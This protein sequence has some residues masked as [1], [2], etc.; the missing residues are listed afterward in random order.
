VFGTHRS[1]RGNFNNNILCI[2]KFLSLIDYHL[3]LYSYTVCLAVRRHILPSFRNINSNIT[4]FLPATESIFV[5]MR[6]C[7]C[8]RACMRARVFD[9]HCR[10]VV[11]T[12][13]SIRKRLESK[14]FVSLYKE[15]MFTNI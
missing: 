7:E 9:F 3:A 15:I 4:I 11:C 14:T 10:M 12:Y 8:M 2:L 6:M 1:I 13:M 5:Y